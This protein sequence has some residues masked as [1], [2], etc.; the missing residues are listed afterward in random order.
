MDDLATDNFSDKYIWKIIHDPKCL[1][2]FLRE[3]QML[4]S[5]GLRV[6]LYD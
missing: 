3:F 1:V 4:V 5:E 2:I 6:I